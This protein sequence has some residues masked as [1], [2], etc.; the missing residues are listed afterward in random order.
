MV[1][2]C[3]SVVFIVGALYFFT[4]GG[5]ERGTFAN[6]TTSLASSAL[7]AAFSPEATTASDTP[8][9]EAAVL[10]THPEGTREYHS[11]AYHFSLF[12]PQELSAAEHPAPN[13]TMTVTFQN[14]D[15]VKGFQIFIVPYSGSQ[16]SMARFKED[17]PSGVRTSVQ[18]ITIQG[19]SGATFYSSD[20]SLGETA[21][22]WFIHG[23]YLYEVTT[24]KPLD[25]WLAGIMQ[26]W[27]FTL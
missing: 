7:A 25:T 17:I 18:N 9:A 10:R 15:E 2:L 13:G 14:V 5:G 27:K 12:Y 1:A 16:I 20:A 3:L 21:E 24:L 6:T 23:G 4:Q 22:L 11:A 8:V 19:A 26:T